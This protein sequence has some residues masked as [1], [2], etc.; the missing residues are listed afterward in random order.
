MMNDGTPH[1]NCVQVL[2]RVAAEVSGPMSRVSK[3]TMVAGAEGGVGPSRV[4]GEVMMTMMMMMI[5]MMMMMMM[6]RCWTSWPTSRAP[7]PG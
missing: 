4:A 1:N 2:P 3:V 7:S 6:L 5:M